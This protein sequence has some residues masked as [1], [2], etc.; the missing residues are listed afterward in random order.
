MSDASWAIV[1]VRLGKDAFDVLAELFGVLDRRHAGR[2]RGG[3]TRRLGGGDHIRKGM[4]YVNVA[5]WPRA[6]N[7]DRLCQRESA[8]LQI[9][10][11]NQDRER[12]CRL[13]RCAHAALRVAIVII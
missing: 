9:V 13:L 1:L 10:D 6:G 12:P 8:L 5:R 7:R 3:C 11:T 2:A 4:H